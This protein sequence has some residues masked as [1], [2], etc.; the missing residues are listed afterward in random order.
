[1]IRVPPLTSKAQSSRPLLADGEDAFRRAALIREQLERTL[2]SP[3]FV[4]SARM[5]QFLRFVVENSLCAGDSLKETVIGVEVFGRTP[6]YDPGLEPIVRIEARRLRDKLKQY[7]AG[8]GANDSVLITL[9]KGGYTPE[10][11]FQEAPTLH[12]EVEQP[13]LS[14]PVPI[15]HDVQSGAVPERVGG[16]IGTRWTAASLLLAGEGAFRYALTILVLILVVAAGYGI[17]TSFGNRGGAAPF[18]SFAI[19]QVTNTGKAAFAAISP[20]GKYV[21]R[22]ENDNGKQALW[23]QNVPTDS[24]VRIVEP[25]GATY[26]HLAFSPDGN[27]LY[28]LES[29]DKTGNN[30]NLYRVPVLGGEPRQIV[31]DVDSDV[32]FS[33]N[34][35]RMAYFRGNDPIAGE[36]RLLSANPDGTGEKVLLALKTALPPLWLSWSPDGKHIAYSLR[37]GDAGANAMGGIGLLD[38]ASGKNSKLAMFTDKVLYDLHWLPNGRGL[39]VVYGARPVVFRRQI[40]LVA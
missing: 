16:W 4:N 7:Y 14:V 29:A 36:S 35:N 8:Q 26:S 33:P 22:V 37:R 24:D 13:A 6:G 21:F 9:P 32:A 12:V 11:S 30:R 28:F 39:V 25:S 19:T 23:L 2:M 1:M 15:T 18:Q 31:R 20:D 38:L 10:F 40:G 27:Y 17:Y 34:G 3:G 5:C